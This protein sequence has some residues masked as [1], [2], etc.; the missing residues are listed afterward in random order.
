MSVDLPSEVAKDVPY[1]NSMVVGPSLKIFTFVEAGLSFS[2]QSNNT[3]F[4]G[5]TGLS[6]DYIAKVIFLSSSSSKYE[7]DATESTYKI[8]SF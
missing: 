6:L 4:D 7:E 2:L 5:A 8:E 3:F 1:G